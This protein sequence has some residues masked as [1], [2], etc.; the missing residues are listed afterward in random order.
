MS[1]FNLRVYGIILQNNFVLVADEHI[2]GIS[3]TK[4]PGG[5]LHFGE[6]TIDCLKREMKEE[7]NINIGQ[8]EHFYTTDFFQPSVFNPD[9]QVISIY[10]LVKHYEPAVIKTSSKKFDFTKV[11]NGAI[12]FRW[13]SR[14]EI[15]E[16]E[17]HFPI[18]K[19]VV[20]KLEKIIF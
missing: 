6:G 5:G 13:L 1:T 3:F 19:I 15:N 14:D 2:N 17:F 8:P 9:Q 7:L 10:Y 11:E 12:S 20:S 16:E 18:D 4:F